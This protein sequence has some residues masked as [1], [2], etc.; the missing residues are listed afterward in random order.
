M[1]AL[2][3]DDQPD[4][5]CALTCLLQ[6]ES[7]FQLTS[8]ASSA[9]ELLAY[10]SV[11]CPDL[12]LLDWELSGVSGRDLMAQIRAVCPNAVVIALSVRPEARLE[13]LES[14]VQGFVSKGDPPERL[15][16]MVRRVI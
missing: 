10:L 14:G 2:L 6:Q 1:H 3:A 8:E 13:A 9:T 7:D 16:A 11:S 15:L 4:V 12:V 5:R